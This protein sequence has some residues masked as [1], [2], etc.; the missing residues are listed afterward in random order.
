VGIDELLT[1]HYLEAELFHFNPIKPAQ[2]WALTK[3][4]QAT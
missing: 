1:Y 4:Q 3:S 2:H